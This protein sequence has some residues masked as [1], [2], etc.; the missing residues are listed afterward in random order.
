[1]RR[2]SSIPLVPFQ[3]MGKSWGGG[4]FKTVANVSRVKKVQT[5]RSLSGTGVASFGGATAEKTLLQVTAGT[6]EGKN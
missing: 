1:M 4:Q 5:V 6:G 2:S 3:V